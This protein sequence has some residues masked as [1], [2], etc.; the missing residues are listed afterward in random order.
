M[1]KFIV[2]LLVNVFGAYFNHIDDTDETYGYFEPLHYLLFG[3]GMQTWEY[4]PDYA[5]RSYAFLSPFWIIGLLL[6]YFG[7]QKIHIFYA[8]KLLLGWFSAYSAYQ[9]IKSIEITFNKRISNLSFILLLFSPGIAYASTSFL[10]S[11]VAMNISMLAA[12]SFM[13]QKETTFKYNQTIFWG[14]IAVLWTGWPFIAVIFVPF[15]VAILFKLSYLQH[16][17]KKI[18]TLIV[19]SVTILLVVGGLASYIDV[20]LYQ[21]W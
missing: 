21:R 5:I 3:K 8:I 19:S 11:A 7:F 20:Q 16:Q 2:L 15:G 17:M 14:C 10:P 13:I 1:I 4:S 6:K 12:A 18:V 9:F